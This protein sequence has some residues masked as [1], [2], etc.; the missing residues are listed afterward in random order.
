MVLLVGGTGRTGGRVL[1][2][3]LERGLAVRAIVRSALRL[4]ESAR[5]S[6]LL[7][8]VEADLLSLTS[9]ELQSHLHGCDTVISCL[10]HT[11]S[12]KGIFGPPFSIVTRAVSN[13]AAAV[14][15]MQPTT[16]VRFILMSSVSVHQPGKREQAHGAGQRLVLWVL[17]VLVPPA[18]DNQR[19]AEFFA[20]Q[21][22]ATHSQI[23]WVA[24]RPDTLRDGHVTDY[25]LHDELVSSIFHP[26]ETNM[27]NVAHFMCELTC[28]DET[29]TCWRGRMPVIVNVRATF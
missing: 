20:R 24:V 28:D 8:V 3:L 17:R 9:K 25:R 7:N 27:A 13:L 21:I 18:R 1:A 26:D 15:A 14:E 10:G 12:V 16:P 23:A 11:L 2:Q 4:P 19:A 29:W 22:G 6:R 5:G